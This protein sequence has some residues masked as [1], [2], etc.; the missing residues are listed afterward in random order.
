MIKMIHCADIHLDSRMEANLSPEQARQRNREL[1]NSFSRMADYAVQNGVSIVLI[2]GDL[3]DS[4]RISATTVSFLLD[5]IRRAA[6]VDFL[7]LRGN[8][9]S[10]DQAFSGQTLPDNLRL[11]S[12]RWVCYDY[13]F[14]T[15]CGLEWNGD[16]DFTA[17][18]SLA[19]DPRR[20]NIVTLHGQI[21]TQPGQEL[22]CLPSLKGKNID[23][24]ALGHIHSYSCQPLDVDSV[25]CYSG[26]LEGRGFDECGEK[27][28]VL[29]EI[30]PKQ[31]RSTFVPFACRT[32][33][34]VNVDITGKTTVSQI[35]QAMNQA[36]EG[37]SADSM[38]KFTLQGSYT[39]ETQKDLAFLQQLLEPQFYFVKIKDESHLEI[40]K[41]SYE[42]DISL[43]GSFIRTVM[44]S[45]LTEAEQ[46]QIIC[47][48]IQALSGEVITL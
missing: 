6:E 24:L 15:V 32:L 42:H 35:Q 23:Y 39:L 47:A 37:I 2:A 16:N 13:D 38:V 45:S 46:E 25:C 4:E 43:K 10:T 12:D 26:C 33:Y 27:G 8:H 34:E 28:F 19:L 30:Q 17:Y 31:I 21:A 7:Y 40:Q 29:L 14:L 41:E 44:A 48:G 3:F 36:A 18:D 11:F 5:V 20:T 9:D 1:C 22:V